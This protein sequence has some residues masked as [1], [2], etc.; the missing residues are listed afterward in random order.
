MHTF[1]DSHSIHLV[2]AASHKSS[3]ASTVSPDYSQQKGGKT[4]WMEHTRGFKRSG[5]GFTVLSN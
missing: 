2:P 4:A 5:L 3:E 1:R